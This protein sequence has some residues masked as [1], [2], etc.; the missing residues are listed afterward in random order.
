MKSKA[1]GTTKDIGLHP[2][3]IPCPIC[4]SRYTY[5]Y[6]PDEWVCDDCVIAGRDPIFKV[7][8][9]VSYK[10][11]YRQRIECQN[12]LLATLRTTATHDTDNLP[13]MIGQTPQWKEVN[14]NE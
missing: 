7:P 1:K 11:L 8:Q 5:V 3:G 2:I 10:E 4:G 13:D 14:H 12:K 6:G 9:R